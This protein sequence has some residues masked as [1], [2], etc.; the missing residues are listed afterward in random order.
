LYDEA[1]EKEYL[2]RR[3]YNKDGYDKTKKTKKVEQ[4]PFNTYPT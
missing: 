3:Q 1:L 4:C 2:H